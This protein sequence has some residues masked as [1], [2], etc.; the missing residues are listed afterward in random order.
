M[1]ASRHLAPEPRGARQGN[2]SEG[3]RDQDDEADQS[4]SHEQ[5][6]SHPPLGT[7][8]SHH[9]GTGG[10]ALDGPA[11]PCQDSAHV[12]EPEYP[13]QR[14]WSFSEELL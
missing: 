12:A 10:A 11:E 6:G 1:A 7:H 13:E 9:G 14:R 5:A 3:H 8:F 4:H 2:L